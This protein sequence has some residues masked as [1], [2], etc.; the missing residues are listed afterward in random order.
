MASMKMITM[1]ASKQNTSKTVSTR[2]SKEDPVEIA[3]PPVVVYYT[4]AE[5]QTRYDVF[6]MKKP[7]HAGGCLQWLVHSPQPCWFSTTIQKMSSQMDTKEKACTLATPGIEIVKSPSYTLQKK[8]SYSIEPCCL[9]YK[10]TLYRRPMCLA[11]Q[12]CHARKTKVP[13]SFYIFFE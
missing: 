7:L 2:A 13:G 1:M 9:H 6:R 11:N 5:Y 4:K 12:T 10:L 3:R 8:N